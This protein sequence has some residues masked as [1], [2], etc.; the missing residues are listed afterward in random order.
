MKYQFIKS[1]INGCLP[2]FALTYSHLPHKAVGNSLYTMLTIR[3]NQFEDG[4]NHFGENE[5]SKFP[6]INQIQFILSNN[7]KIT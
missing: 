3:K 7:N 6:K 2:N 5:N 4:Y 1:P